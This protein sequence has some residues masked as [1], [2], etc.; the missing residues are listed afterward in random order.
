MARAA[1]EWGIDHPGQAP[2]I[3]KSMGLVVALDDDTK[4]LM[5][6]LEQAAGPDWDNLEDDYIMSVIVSSQKVLRRKRA[7]L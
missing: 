6:R 5:G 7:R 4:D 3:D 2:S 1:L